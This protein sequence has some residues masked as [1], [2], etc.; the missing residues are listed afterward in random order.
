MALLPT[1][2]QENIN[3]NDAISYAGRQ[4]YVDGEKSWSFNSVDNNTLRFE[5]RKGDQFSDSVWTDP[6]GVERAEMSDFARYSINQDISVEYKFMIEAGAKNTAKWVVVGQLHSA[7]SVTPPVEIKFNGNDKMA[8][9]GKS[10]SSSN[11]VY[12]DLYKDSQDIV[13]GHW[14]TMKMNIHF[15]PH[16]NGSADIWRDG[17]QI[18]D[19]NGAL[20]YTDQT[21][22]YWKEGVYRATAAETFAVNYKDLSIKTGAGAFAATAQATPSATA[23]ATLSATA[24]NKVA[25]WANGGLQ[26]NSGNDDLQGT[27]GDDALSGYGGRDK[28]AGI[29]GSD[30]LDGGTSQDTLLGGGGND[31]LYGR[32][33]NDRLEGGSDHDHLYGCGGADR[34]FGGNG[35]DKL[36]GGTGKDVLTGGSGA[37]TFVLASSLGPSGHHHRLQ[38][39]RGLHPAFRFGLQGSAERPPG[40][41]RLSRSARSPRLR[42]NTSFTTT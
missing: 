19:Y 16:G 14:Y 34:L 6:I 11:I 5:V 31:T 27:S 28:L 15:D 25:N 23:Q 29:G 4:F 12:R 36:N 26:G 10:G 1:V 39:S 20:G 7:M 30:R 18:V 3:D 24:G 22:T 37:D 13:R 17:V 35:D 40:P 2:W 32:T 8:I 38:L 9:S 41:D 33:G 21:Q 42:I